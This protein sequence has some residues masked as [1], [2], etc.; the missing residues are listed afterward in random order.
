MGENAK[1]ICV[2]SSL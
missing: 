2:G 1:Q